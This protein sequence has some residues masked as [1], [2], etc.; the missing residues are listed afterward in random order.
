MTMLA[1]LRVKSDPRAVGGDVDVLV[2]VGAVEGERV[3]AGLAL[4]DVVAVAGRPAERV[5]ARAQQ[6]DVVA[7][8]A[9]HGVVAVAAEQEVGAGAARERVVAGAAVERRAP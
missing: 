4:H 8:A 6:R 9:D 1:M 2:D 5:V 7:A 3:G